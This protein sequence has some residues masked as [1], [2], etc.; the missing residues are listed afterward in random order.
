MT[1]TQARHTRRAVLQ[2]AVDASAEC[3]TVDLDLFF[4]EDGEPYIEWQARRAEVVRVC[5][6]CPA[7]AACTELA[8][9]D[10]DGRP[11]RDDMVR[12]GLTG[13]E[14]ADLRDRQAVRL[15]AATAVDRDT[16]GQE[17]DRLVAELRSEAIT[18]PD[19]GRYGAVRNTALR[20][21]AQ[22]AVL[23]TL[24]ARIS[25]IRTGR[26]ARAGWGVAA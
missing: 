24:A 13:P 25:T 17:L 6:G 23:R 15:A 20:T 26:R 7:R 2:A 10:G 8:L 3:A 1:S 14:L 5:V 4:R 19:S 9:R 18:S 21:A 12:A 22:N 11:D 16:E